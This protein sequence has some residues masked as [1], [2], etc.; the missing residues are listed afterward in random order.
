MSSVV[1]TSGHSALTLSGSVPDGFVMTSGTSGWWSVSQ[2]IKSA[3][4][5]L[6]WVCNLPE[7]DYVL[8]SA[9]TPMTRLSSP[10]PSHKEL[11][12]GDLKVALLDPGPLEP[13]SS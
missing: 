6:G 2:L 5:T 7:G 3:H 13:W 10:S 4:F 9:M 11:C 12:V 1:D 8:D